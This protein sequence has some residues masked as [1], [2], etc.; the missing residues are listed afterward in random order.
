MVVSVF[1]P[2]SCST[3][4][5]GLDNVQQAAGGEDSVQQPTDDRASSG[6]PARSQLGASTLVLAERKGPRQG[7][8]QM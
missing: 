7:G 1:F 8:H 3:M 2:F 5:S 6:R 4:S